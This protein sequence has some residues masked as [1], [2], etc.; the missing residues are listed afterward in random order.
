HA[1]FE[2]LSSRRAS[3][4]P[5]WDEENGKVDFARWAKM[6]SAPDIDLALVLLGWNSSTVPE[7]EYLDDVRTFI[8]N[9]RAAFPACRIV[10]LG[11]QVPS[12][13]GFGQ[14]YGCMWNWRSMVDYIT[15]MDRRYEIIAGEFENVTFHSLAGQFDREYGYPTVEEAPNVRSSVRISRQSNG[16]HPSFEGYMQIAD[17]MTRAV[18]KELAAL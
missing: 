2:I 11:L 5:F 10:L 12:Q 9:L 8:R 7:E 17:A 16:V 4:N 18:V 6:L 15:R 14:N 1:D 13:D 3:G